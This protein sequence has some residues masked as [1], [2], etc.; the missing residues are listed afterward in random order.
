MKTLF[1]YSGRLGSGK[2]FQMLKKVEELKDQGNVIYLVSF[3]DPIKNIIKNSFG[4]TKAGKV[5]K[6]KLPEMTNIYVKYQV[7]DA[8]Y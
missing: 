1:G 3:A 5:S 7:V 4:F 6:A 2:N 8:L